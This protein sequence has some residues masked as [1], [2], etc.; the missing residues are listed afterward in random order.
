ME[1]EIK[2]LND[3]IKTMMKKLND[4]VRTNAEDKNL[5]ETSKTESE[6][7]VCKTESAPKEKA[8]ENP[9]ELKDTINKITTMAAKRETKITSR[10]VPDGE[11]SADSQDEKGN[12]GIRMRTGGLFGIALT[13]GIGFVIH[14][15]L[16]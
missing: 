10:D 6:H 8:T 9:D 11:K 12:A 13:I 16:Q 7:E 14:C 3:T 15:A 1:K 5:T 2:S 4:P